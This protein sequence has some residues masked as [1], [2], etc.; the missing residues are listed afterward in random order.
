[1][2]VRTVTCDIVGRTSLHEVQKTHDTNGPPKDGVTCFWSNYSDLTRPHPKWWFSKGNSLIS[3]KSGLVKYYNLTRCL[4]F[5]TWEYM[6][7]FIQKYMNHMK[8]LN[9]NTHISI[10]LLNKGLANT[11]SKDLYWHVFKMMEINSVH[12]FFWNFTV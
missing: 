8:P 11:Q 12:G 3:G 5:G 10:M 6:T 7:K 9:N 1:M 2:R 4:K